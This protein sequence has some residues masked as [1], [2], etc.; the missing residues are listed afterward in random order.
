VKKRSEI[1]SAPK[2]TAPNSGKTGGLAKLERGRSGVE[3][4]RATTQSR[5]SDLTHAKTNWFFGE[6]EVLAGTNLAMLGKHPDR[7]TM[8]LLVAAAQQQMGEPDA[9]LKSAR[10]AIQWGCSSKLVAQILIAGVH[11]TLGR[12]T[13]LAGQDERAASHFKSAVAIGTS[14][15]ED[16]EIVGHSRS[17][18]EMTKLGLLP[19]VAELMDK[20]LALAS[21]KSKRPALADA[22]LKALES[23]LEVLRGSLHLAIQRGQLSGDAKPRSL[24]NLSAS[25][26]GQDL[27]V[28]EQS[29]YKRNGF[30]VEFGATDGILLSNTLLLESRYGWSG[31]CVEPQPGFFDQLK[32]N[33]NCVVLNACIS[34]QTGQ[35][36]EFIQAEEYGGIADY[37]GDDMHADKRQAYRTLG[38]TMQVTTLSLHD[39]LTNQRAP[40]NIDYL[41]VDTEGS[42]YEI[43][44]AFPFDQW[45][46]QC[47][48]V[49]H[50]F[51][52][53][54]EPI[55]QLLQ[56]LGYQRIEAQWDDWYFLNDSK[57]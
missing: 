55:R 50:N 42:E 12:A 53:T 4:S 27:W 13:A 33:R 44:R 25:Q 26:L 6:W 43:L 45:R 15:T 52:E 23:E 17:V 36:V 30:F 21:S 22:R 18:R 41:S 31:I 38:K 14:T 47:I 57:Q 48:T 16:A 3:L 37:A 49:E 7:G 40:H 8:A 5:A 24:S 46:I 10:L 51:S 29:G 20:S 54:R 2:K 34:G 9:A 1:E 32:K 35:Q 11:N 56:P 39:L 19:Q 28:L